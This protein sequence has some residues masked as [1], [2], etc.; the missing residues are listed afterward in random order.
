M[1]YLKKSENQFSLTFKDILYQVR[2]K[3]KDSN[4]EY[5]K[6]I[7]NN[8][9]GQA[10][11]GEITAIMG[12][13][14]SGKTSLL[15]F[16][17]SR[18][19][20]SKSSNFS[21]ELY[22]NEKKIEFDDIGHYSGY[23]MQDDC[24]FPT[25]TPEENLR[26]AIRLKNLTTDEDLEDCTMKFLKDLQIYGCKNSYIGS[27]DLKGIS[28]GERKRVS[29]GMEIVSN[30][31]ILFLDEPTSGLDSQTSLK[32]LSL[33]KK[34][35]V[36]KNIIVVC[37]IHQPSSNIFNIFDKLIIIERG[38]MIYN[39]IPL[40]I[41]KYFKSIGKPLKLKANPADSFMRILEEN[42]KNKNTMNYFIDN[43]KNQDMI[44]RKEIDNY[45]AE[46]NM[47]IN[48]ISKAEDT[49][50]MAL[51]IK[52]LSERSLKNVLRNPTILP[53]RIVSML[54]FAFL[55]ASVF[56][57]LDGATYD[58][59]NGRTG[60]VF[61]VS[62]LVLFQEIMGNILSFPA[63]RAVFIREYYSKMYKLF[64]YYVAKNLVES[65]I[66]LCFAAILNIIVYFCAG[67]RSDAGN[68]F[69]Y[70]A[71]MLL[72][73]LCSQSIAYTIGAL[74]SRVET[75]IAVTNIITLPYVIFS[76]TLLNEDSMP[77]WLGW[78]KYLSPMK[79]SNS[80]GII[81][82]FDGNNDITFKGG[83]EDTLNSYNFDLG[84]KWSFGI[85]AFTT[86]LYRVLGYYFLKMMISKTG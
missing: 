69:V 86:I 4:T 72:L 82:E 16:I 54:I 71:C 31:S 45:L 6:T 22:I 83:W 13:S 53:T 7:I 79:Y 65:P 49:A 64:P 81:N 26:L 74:F 76:G 9:S 46:T 2:I 27:A 20:F 52:I 40:N 60:F 43:Y 41:T 55:V 66:F 37:T 15:N 24:L 62:C 14:G 21:G 51:Q 30:P 84:I 19:N 3:D 75:A 57:K 36:Q 61:F 33:L 85:L 70:F 10:K 25:L 77:K 42:S 58:G 18:I 80:I 17:T 50:S 34:I 63:E 73:S 8:I 11:S 28:G 23:V 29:I 56:W 68:F 67:F 32:I 47:G 5:F 35:A 39:D 38:N 44:N 78:L 48:I 59:V 1:E 12:P